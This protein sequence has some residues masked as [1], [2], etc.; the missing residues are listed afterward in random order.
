[1]E[2]MRGLSPLEGFTKPQES[3]K[4]LDLRLLKVLGS[5]QQLSESDFGIVVA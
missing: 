2:Q 1:M 5:A 3:H 4:L